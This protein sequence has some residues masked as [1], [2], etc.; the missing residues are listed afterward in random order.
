MIL[1]QSAINFKSSINCNGK[2]IDLTVPKVM[3]I[4]NITPDSFYDGSFYNS[5]NKIQDHIE[6]LITGG[7]DFIDLGAHS[8]RPGAEMLSI[9][10]EKERLSPI[11]NLLRKDYPEMII[12]VDTFQ[13]KIAEFAVKDFEVDI[14][15]DISGG[16]LD[17]EMFKTIS[18]LNVPYVMM[19]MKGA[20]EN[21]QN[22]VQYEDI[23]IDIIKYFGKK[24]EKL[25]LLGVKDII[26]DPG[27]GFSKTLEQNFE[28]LKRLDE[29]KI[30]GL[31]LMA[32]LSRKSMI[33]KLLDTGPE[34]ALNGTIA[35]NTLALERGAKILRVHDV[36]EAKEL[37][38][39]MQ[40]IA[41]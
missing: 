7:V 3:G 13:S 2:I 10:E 21:M 30:I 38:Q 22:F 41:N 23:V 34:K 19:H 11:L 14:I 12:S 32:G 26:I 8:S 15:N 24:I 17:A 39:I 36:K 29:F 18:E 28:I 1:N 37:I 20:P 33:Y 5:E 16:N 35:V 27:F 25:K 4:L 40:Q 9:Q 31:P 6:K